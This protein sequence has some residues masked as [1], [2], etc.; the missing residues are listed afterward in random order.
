MKLS[1]SLS[2]S[3]CLSIFLTLILYH[4]LSLSL[5]IYIYIYIY[6]YATMHICPILLSSGYTC[7]PKCI[8]VYMLCLHYTKLHRK[9]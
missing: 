9:S 3:L 1:L 4:F 7:M 5:C 6:I 2:L 8:L